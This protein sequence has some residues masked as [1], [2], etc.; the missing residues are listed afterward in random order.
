MA[1]KSV[2]IVFIAKTEQD[3]F[4]MIRQLEL[5]EY[6]GTVEV[7]YST[8]PGIPQAWNDAISKATCEL[9]LFTETDVVFFDEHWIRDMVAEAELS[10]FVKAREVN[11]SN[12]NWSSTI[13]YRSDLL[14]EKIDES[15]PVAEDT[16]FYL[17][18]RQHG[19]RFTQTNKVFVEHLRPD[20]N[21]KA[22]DRAFDYGYLTAKLIDEQ[23]YY[24]LDFYIERQKIAIDVAQKTLLGIKKYQD[25]QAAKG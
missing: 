13:V 4:N 9:L 10:V 8:I 20:L 15:Y 19:M 3:A 18:M 12:Q 17:R 16:E 25:E 5:Q 24:P 21:Y 22:V 14:D 11:H 6:S 2:S 7:C 1:A 23:K